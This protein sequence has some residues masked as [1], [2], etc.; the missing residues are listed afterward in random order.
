MTT[1]RNCTMLLLASVLLQ[2]RLGSTH[3]WIT[4]PHTYNT[5]YKAKTCQG[6]ECGQPC[7]TKWSNMR[8]SQSAPFKEYE[9]GES[10]DV[11]WVRNSH[12]GG[13]VRL[14]FVPVEAMWNRDAHKRLA[15]F[16]GCWD[17][18]EE[19]CRTKKW[20]GTDKF[21][22]SLH[23]VIDVPRCLPDGDYV[24]SYAWFGGL[25]FTQT[26]GNF[27]DFHHCSHVRV[28]GGA[29]PGSCRAEFDAGVGM[30]SER[31]KCH[32]SATDVGQCVKTGC[33][34]PNSAFYGIPDAFA[35]GRRPDSFDMDDVIYIRD[36]PSESY[37]NWPNSPPST[38]VPPTV[39]APRETGGSRKFAVC[40]AG[41]CCSGGCKACGGD[42][43]H[44]DKSKR[45]DECCRSGV[46]RRRRVCGI[47][48]PPCTCVDG[49]P[50]K[51]PDYID[52][53]TVTDGNDNE[54]GLT[55][56][57]GTDNTDYSKAKC[58]GG[59]CCSVGCR[60]CASGRKCHKDK[61]SASD[62]CCRNAI[63]KSGRDCATNKPP[64]VCEQRRPSF[65]PTAWTH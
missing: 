9:R 4:N 36:Y 38:A 20:C 54:P 17:S 14:G 46:Q 51:C 33:R 62:E 43:C 1:M 27:P 56:D 45:S 48:T 22:R 12:R 40:S 21:G 3:S 28:R 35:A 13:I 39:R 42:N 24:F 5:V 49:N 32:T 52:P 34:T 41:V 29:R 53:R 61:R 59:V 37:D 18:G 19:R 65:C 7:P 50:S 44:L 6:L 16:Y 11:K 23:K 64:C 55:T 57:G 2:A 10:L 60:D 15:V 26:R 30:S 25:D 8:N 58:A 31:G 47:D 63:V